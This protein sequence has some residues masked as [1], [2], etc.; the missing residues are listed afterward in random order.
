M[1]YTAAGIPTKNHY[2]PYPP[3]GGRAKKEKAIDWFEFLPVELNSDKFKTAWLE[4]V[5]YRKAIKKPV[6]PASALRF[7]EV[8]LKP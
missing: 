4:W 7:S 8:L 3:A 6:N 1:P 2:I 5:E